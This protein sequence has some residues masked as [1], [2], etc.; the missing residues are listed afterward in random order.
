MTTIAAIFSSGWWG[1]LIVA[2][3]IAAWGIAYHLF[4]RPRGTP[5][6]L[7]ILR[8]FGRGGIA[9]AIAD[10]WQLD[11]GATTLLAGPEWMD[12]NPD[13]MTVFAA[14]DAPDPLAAI[15]ARGKAI[16]NSGDLAVALDRRKVDFFRQHVLI[17]DHGVWREAV[18]RLVDQADYV[19]F[20]LSG[21][22]GDAEGCRFELELLMERVPIDRVLYVIDAKT[23][24]STV[25]TQMD[26]ACARQ[27]VVATPLTV[28]RFAEETENHEV[29]KHLRGDRA[30]LAFRRNLSRLIRRADARTRDRDEPVTATG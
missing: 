30:L 25:K 17:C 7:L 8:V 28:L 22:H 26:R 5:V 3:I 13:P 24:W 10:V 16:R 9:R 15:G 12:Q 2:V 1:L 27:S 6:D 11:E 21:F 19:L 4:L 23:D 20:D 29:L 14:A 18:T